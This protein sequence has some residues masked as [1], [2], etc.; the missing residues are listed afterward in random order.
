MLWGWGPLYATSVAL[1]V[2]QLA[3]RRHLRQAVTRIVI[4]L[5]PSRYLELPAARRELAARP[6]DR[7]LDLASPKLLAV[8]LAREGVEVVSAD[9]FAAEIEAWRE[10]AA[11]EGRVR[12]EVAD[13]R[14]LPFEAASFDHAYSVSVLEHV[15]GEGGDAAALRELARVVRPGGRVFATVPH[16]G[17]ARDEYRERPLYGE[18]VAENGRFFFQRWYDVTRVDALVAAVPELELVRRQVV[19]LQPNWNAAYTRHFPWLLP[20]GPLYGLLAREVERDDGD[21][22]RLTF[23]RR[24]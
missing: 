3:R 21:V 18:Q 1:G 9:A 20:L 15:G 23:R 5:D 7:V 10:L 11:G 14:A 4:P 24:E 12:F 22:A 16:A 13:G 2:R 19:R 17:R 8:A 6:G